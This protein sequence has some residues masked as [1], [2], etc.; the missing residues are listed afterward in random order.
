MSLG[1]ASCLLADPLGG[2]GLG[3]TVTGCEVKTPRSRHQALLWHL[4][5]RGHLHRCLVV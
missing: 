3:P 4:W 5:A 2:T 1:L